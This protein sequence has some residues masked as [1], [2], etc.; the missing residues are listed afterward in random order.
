ML[1]I[2]LVV[3]AV[4]VFLKWRKSGGALPPSLAA[5]VADIH[6]ATVAYDAAIEKAAKQIEID[7]LAK[8]RAVSNIQDRAAEAAKVAEQVSAPKAP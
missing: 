5:P 1:V 4:V 8:I 7:L 3:V 6:A 2:I